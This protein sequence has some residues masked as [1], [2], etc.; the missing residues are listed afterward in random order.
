MTPTG[1][2]RSPLGRISGQPWGR[3]ENP[4]QPHTDCC[5]PGPAGRRPP[6]GRG[7]GEPRRMQGRGARGPHR[8]QPPL[9]RHP[10]HLGAVDPALLEGALVRVAGTHVAVLTPVAG[11][12]AANAGHA[13]G[14]GGRRERLQRP[15]R[16]QAG[17]SPP[18]LGDRGETEGRRHQGPAEACTAQQGMTRRG[19]RG[20]QGHYSRLMDAAVVKDKVRPGEPHTRL[21][22]EQLQP[23]RARGPC[24]KAKGGRE[25]AG[26]QRV[27]PPEQPSH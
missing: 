9:A 20:Q 15:Q 17:P 26:G 7:S 23:H 6:H 8:A 19:G 4:H 13:P 24:G 10:P 5:H 27:P 11:V 3:R 18:L 1:I 12:R 14:G 21:L 25:P 2:R 22:G 16:R